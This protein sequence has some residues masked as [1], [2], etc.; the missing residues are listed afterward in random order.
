MGTKANILSG[1]STIYTAPITAGVPVDLPDLD[2][3]TG[4]DTL[5]WTSWTQVGFTSDAGVEVDY[6]N[7]VEL[8]YV[9]EFAGAIKADKIK[10]EMKVSWEFFEKILSAYAQAMG[11]TTTTVAAGAGQSGQTVLSIGGVA[12]AEFSLA[13][14]GVN[15]SGKHRVWHFPIVTPTVNM[16][17]TANKKSNPLAAEFTAL[18]DPTTG[19]LCHVYDVTA[20]PTS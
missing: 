7:E 18:A 15:P 10:E 9:C 1:K 14:Q 2:A 20:A 5:A 11:L 12:L 17:D 13:L 3:S 16:K 4:I 6:S 19:K 8:V